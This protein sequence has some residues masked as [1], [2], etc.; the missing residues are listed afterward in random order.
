MK[1]QELQEYIVNNDKLI[2]ILE[3]LGM[4]HINSSNAKYV[5]CGMPDGDNPMS[6]IVYKDS[7]LT[8][9]AY[10]R[11]L[12][13][14]EGK[15]T[16]IFNLIMFVKNVNFA[17]AIS[18]AHAILGLSNDRSGFTNREDVSSKYRKYKSKNKNKHTTREQVYYGL[19]ILDQY[20]K[21]P[22]IDLIKDGIFDLKVIQKY[23]VLF[24]D[25]SNRIVFP[26]LKHDDVNLICGITGRTVVKAYKELKI[27]KYMSMLPTEYIKTQNL[28]GL[29]LNRDNIISKGVVI[30]F[31]AEKSVMKAEQMGFD[32]GVSLGCHSISEIQAKIL[33]S[34]NVEICIAF[35]KDVSEEHIRSTC[36][37]FLNTGR[38]VSYVYDRWHLLNEK[39]SP[40]DRG[41][42]KWKYLYR[43]RVQ[44]TG[45]IEQREEGTGVYL[46][47][48]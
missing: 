42:K 27:Q 41:L 10:T 20:I 39:D 34:L 18:W 7:Y 1:P 48:K 43:N 45:D 30:V 16:N 26:H 5:S 22:H 37:R 35:D 44:Y 4:K 23:K 25:R 36:N 14:E 40:V 12:P 19:H 3:E 9:N 31:E 21:T 15:N 17:H 8:V 6:T 11:K 47:N 32:N 28:Y 33:L 29:S 2:Y 38:R 46:I 13:G 24:D